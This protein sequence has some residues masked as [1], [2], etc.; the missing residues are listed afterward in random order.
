M[1]NVDYWRTIRDKGT[2]QETVLTDEQIDIIQK[3]QRSGYP[4]QSVDP[5]EVSVII[6]YPLLY[7]AFHLLL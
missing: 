3:L 4:E 1:D 2:G 5:Y 7:N 6:F